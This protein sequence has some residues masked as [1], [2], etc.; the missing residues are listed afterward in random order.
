MSNE[1]VVAQNLQH[2]ECK[3]FVLPESNTAKFLVLYGF[4]IVGRFE[5]VEYEMMIC[6]SYKYL[7]IVTSSL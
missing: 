6:T 2:I 3:V 4:D 5:Y 7:Y 1:F